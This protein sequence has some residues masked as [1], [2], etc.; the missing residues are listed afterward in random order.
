MH[1][2]LTAS[3]SSSKSTCRLECSESV[4]LA[5]S[6]EEAAPSASLGDDAHHVARDENDADETITPPC[7]KITD[8]PVSMAD[9]YINVEDDFA[10]GVSGSLHIHD[11]AAANARAFTAVATAAPVGTGFAF[12]SGF[13]EMVRHVLVGLPSTCRGAL[14]VT[15]K[16]CGP[17]DYRDPVEPPPGFDH[18][19]SRCVSMAVDLS[20]LGVALSA[21]FPDNTPSE[22]VDHGTVVVVTQSFATAGGWHV[23]PQASNVFQSA[24]YPFCMR[25]I[26]ARDDG[27]HT[28]ISG[29]V[30]AVGSGGHAAGHRTCERTES[31]SSSHSHVSDVS[32]ERS[33][34]CGNHVAAAFADGFGT[35]ATSDWEAL[36]SLVQERDGEGG[37]RAFW[38]TH[39]LRAVFCGSLR[40]TLTRLMT[41]R[42]RV[43]L[44]R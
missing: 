4:A 20:V 30:S 42:F 2:I 33:R 6:L 31:G 38:P 26:C 43:L 41:N 21:A 1:E 16:T 17:D 8:M 27:A 36:C 14:V 23:A 24:V 44:M 22:E 9:R 40:S 15:D 12:Y 13:L 25:E 19:S 39:R 28:D 34:G 5:C 18:H 32:D 7:F 37:H 35:F 29:R 10:H 3:S 11:V